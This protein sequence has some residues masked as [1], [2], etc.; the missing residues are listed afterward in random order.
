MSLRRLP[1]NLDVFSLRGQLVA[2][3][4]PLGTSF[5]IR[6]LAVLSRILRVIFRILGH[7]LSILTPSWADLGHLGTILERCW[8]ILGPSC[9]YLGPSWSYLAPSRGN[10]KPSW[11]HL[12]D[13]FPPSWAI[14]AIWCLPRPGGMRNAFES[15]G[16]PCARQLCRMPGGTYSAEVIRVIGEFPFPGH[17]HSARTDALWPFSAPLAT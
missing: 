16:G 14:G 8:A 11:G 7:V 2:M 13:M 9:S 6:F 4:V 12:G 5:K 17:A 10:L 15:G 3:L 1:F